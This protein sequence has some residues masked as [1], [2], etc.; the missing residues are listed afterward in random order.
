MIVTLTPNP[1]LDLTY[2]L[3]KVLL[4]GVQRATEFSV[5]AGG[6]G[7]NVSRNLVANGVAS[8]AVAPVGGPSGE[9]FLGLLE[10]SG[11][12]LARVPVS[13]P[14]RAN[15]TVV[16][17][18]GVVT[19]INAAGPRLS[20]VEVDLLLEE[21]A[22]AGRGADWV[23]ACG[24]LP[25]G[26]PV[27]LLARVVEAARESGCRAVV[28]SSGAPL[29][30]ALKATPDVM[31]PNLEELSEIVDRRLTTFGDVL[32][33]AEEVRAA[34]VSTLFVSLGADGAVLVDGSGARHADTP[35]F[36]PRS[37]VGAGDALLAGFLAAGGEGEAAL[38]EGVAWGAAA[39]RLPGTRT[40]TPKDVDRESV[41]V[42]NDI[43][44]ERQL[45][46]EAPR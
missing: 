10:E 6:K 36:T 37:T 21:T 34:G 31:K 23:A 4:G 14:V 16:D 17:R 8:R 13:G 5:E 18:E 30:A 43:D 39:A 28:D 42:H 40:L 45:K 46:G 7:I 33:A 15:V 41:R 24:S 26:A 38:V 22:A 19:K 27:D 1:S 35:P 25:P 32:D 12:E 3:E 9:Q 20:A 2:E 29:A 44:R 11:I